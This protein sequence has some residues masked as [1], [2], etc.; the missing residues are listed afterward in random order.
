MAAASETV[1]D[2]TAEEVWGEY[3]DEEEE[4]TEVV[5][6][7]I[8]DE[9]IR[10]AVPQK[11]FAAVDLVS[12]GIVGP[13]I[14][15]SFPLNFRFILPDSTAIGE[16][17]GKPSDA[18]IKEAAS[19]LGL[20]D[21]TRNK[22]SYWMAD[23]TQE[24]LVAAQKQ[25]MSQ[26]NQVN[27][28]N[29]F[30]FTLKQIQ[31]TPIARKQ[32]FSLLEEMLLEAERMMVAV[33]SENIP[34][35]CDV[36]KKQDVNAF[37][38]YYTAVVKDVSKEE[39]QAAKTKKKQ[40]KQ[41]VTSKEKLQAEV[42]EE[43]AYGEEE[44]EFFDPGPPPI[45]E[46]DL[47]TM[48]QLLYDVFADRLAYEIIRDVFWEEPM[49]E[50]IRISDRFLPPKQLVPEDPEILKSLSNE[51]FFPEPPVTIE[52]LLLPGEK[53]EDLTEE[54]KLKR[55]QGATLQRS[56]DRFMQPMADAIDSSYFRKIYPDVKGI[57]K[58]VFIKRKKMEQYRREHSSK[59]P[60]E[61]EKANS[62]GR[63]SKA[64]GQQRKSM[65]RKSR[66]STGGKRKS[67]AQRKSMKRQ[68]MKRKSKAK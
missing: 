49:V 30:L 8:A 12:V 16:F 47:M 56:K 61:K 27:T 66:A 60:L 13:E 18:T 51:A 23:V 22:Y 45:T 37:F 19:I 32:F 43:E 41:S 34:N 9:V 39:P 38:V 57:S 50:V 48:T 59:K 10:V 24:M 11:P 36:L 6:V 15:R 40:S 55:V 53:V 14:V 64:G 5:E 26:V 17:A 3:G 62:S 67:T 25:G 31:L 21:I 52:E 28:I 29:W 46:K 20:T 2:S 7:N 58:F 54:E 4:E 65:K 44:G 1:T 35:P 33:G 63:K 68:S 42:Q